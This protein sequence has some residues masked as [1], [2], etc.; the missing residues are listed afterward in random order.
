LPA[1]DSLVQC[2]DLLTQIT[3]PVGVQQL[4]CETDR[5]PPSNAEVMNGGVIH[6]DPHASLWCGALL[7]K[8]T[9]KFTSHPYSLEFM[10][11]TLQ[12]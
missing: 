8:N 6:P 12:F 4:E 2:C 3:I 9:D 5:S 10:C 1:F 11:Y 7:I